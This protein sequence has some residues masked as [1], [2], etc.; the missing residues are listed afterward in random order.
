MKASYYIYRLES[1]NEEGQMPQKH[2]YFFW[3]KEKMQEQY[4]KSYFGNTLKLVAIVKNARKKQLEW[5]KNIKH[6]VPKE[7][8]EDI[9]NTNPRKRIFQTSELK[10][11]DEIVI[12]HPSIAQS[13]KEKRQIFQA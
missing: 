9:G 2:W 10:I 11:E 4:A 12:V 7:T 6:F 1:I 5:Q 13:D 3:L 8:I